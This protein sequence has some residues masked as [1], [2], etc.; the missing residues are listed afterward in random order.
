MLDNHGCAWVLTAIQS[1]VG[2]ET[3]GIKTLQ[4]GSKPLVSSS[5][6]QHF[7]YSPGMAVASLRC[8]GVLVVH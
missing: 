8:L 6:H 3:F 2:I 7:E 1:F 5:W 4:A